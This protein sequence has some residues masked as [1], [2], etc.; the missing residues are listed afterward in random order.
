[1]IGIIK[2]M[3]Y[4]ATKLRFLTCRPFWIHRSE[5]TAGAWPKESS[6]LTVLRVQGFACRVEVKSKF[7]V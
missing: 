7:R 5:F 6:E 2:S 1:M 4:Y 3:S